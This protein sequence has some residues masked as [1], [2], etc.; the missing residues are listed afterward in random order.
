MQH[1]IF[2]TQGAQIT[3]DSRCESALLFLPAGY[4]HGSQLFISLSLFTVL[5]KFM[6]VLSREIQRLAFT[7]QE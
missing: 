3:S 7:E 4:L 6:S 2:A 1:I 5:I